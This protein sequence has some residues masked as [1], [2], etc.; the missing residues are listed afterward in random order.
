M[1]KLFS[2]RLAL[3]T[4]ASPRGISGN[5]PILGNTSR[6]H[7]ALQPGTCLTNLLLEPSKYSLADRLLDSG[8]KKDMVESWIESYMME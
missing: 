4:E 8:A 5:Q 3:K 6:L 7:E 2:Q 1:G